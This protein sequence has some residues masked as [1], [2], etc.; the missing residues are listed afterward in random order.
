MN[1][2]R[3]T[4]FALSFPLLLF[5]FCNI[6]AQQN[7]PNGDESI[8]LS[9]TKLKIE[10]VAS[11]LDFPTTMAFL[12]PDDFLILEKNTGNVKRFVNGTM[13]EKPLLHVKPSIKDERGLLGI[14]ISEKKNL[15][16]NGASIKNNNISHNIFL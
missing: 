13:L 5:S 15:N 2:K 4:I 11:G 8:V 10:L 14:A 9:D 12:G 7:Q 6:Y 16:D 3:I 1:R